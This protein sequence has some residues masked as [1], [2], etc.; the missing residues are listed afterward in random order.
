MESIKLSRVFAVLGLLFLLGAG[1]WFAHNQILQ[2]NAGEAVKTVTEQLYQQLPTETKESVPAAELTPSDL[3]DYL[4]FPDLPMPV[5]EI[6]GRM[7]IGFL[8]LPTIDLTLGVCSTWDYDS[9]DISPCRYSGSA[10]QDNL[11]IA[12]HN[13]ETHFRNISQV[14]PGDPVRFTDIDGNV[15]HY[16]AVMVE[17]LG[18]RDVEEM[19]ESDFALTLFTCTIGGAQRVALRCERVLFPAQTQQS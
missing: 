13:Y 16:R 1:F 4:L 11:V 10:Y 14:Q 5:V 2:A 3:P 7:Y 17:I 15:F 9:L 8:E 18:P 6:E 19:T 12:G